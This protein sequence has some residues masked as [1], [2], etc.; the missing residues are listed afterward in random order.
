MQCSTTSLNKYAYTTLQRHN[1]NIIVGLSV[2]NAFMP[3]YMLQMIGLYKDPEGKKVFDMSVEM[4]I[5]A[6]DRGIGA[7][8]DSDTVP[9]LKRRITE[10][11][12]IVSTYKVYKMSNTTTMLLIILL[13]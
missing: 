7:S 1:N 11:E 2:G 6:A 8:A 9:S 5:A 4:T 10:L 12:N 13:W 3:L